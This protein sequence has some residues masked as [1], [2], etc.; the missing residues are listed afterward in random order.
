MPVIDEVVHSLEKG[1]V[2]PGWR[3]TRLYKLSAIGACSVYWIKFTDE[4][5][6]VNQIDLVVAIRHGVVSLKRAIL[7]RGRKLSAYKEILEHG[8]SFCSRR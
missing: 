5:E 7:W 6:P 4:E 2:H 3:L 8:Y 1:F